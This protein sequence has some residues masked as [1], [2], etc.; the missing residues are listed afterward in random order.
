MSEPAKKGG[1]WTKAMLI[2]LLGVGGGAAGTYATAVVDRVVK[3]TKPVAN[4]ATSADGLTLT[5]Q[6]HASGESG[7]WDFGDGSALEPFKADGQAVTHAYAKPGTYT[8]KLTVRNYFSDENERSV[9]VE[10]GAAKDAPVPAVSGFAVLPVSGSSVAPATFRLTAEVKNA[11]NSVCDFGGRLEVADGGKIDRMV[12]FDTPGTYGVQLIAHN[13]KQA[14]KQT[15]TVTVTAP[16]EGTTMALLKVTDGGTRV[17]RISLTETVAIPVP[18][19]KKA[20]FSKAV[21]ARPGFVIADVTFPGAVAG[22]KNIKLAIAAN[23]QSATL[24]GDWADPKTA[25]KAAGGSDVIVPLKMVEER[26]RPL[27]TA[28]TLVTGAF[29][30]GRADLPLPSPPEGVT[31]ATRTFEIEIRATTGGKSATV[32]Q[33]KGAVA[34]PWSGANARGTK[35]TAKLDGDKVVVTAGR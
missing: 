16:A 32:A 12:T 10:V 18:N 14:V 4:F 15:A 31:G 25:N 33:G 3:P 34:L 24:S 9:P 28:T 35:Y 27:P 5:C 2:G 30:G 21:A 22:A 11:D 20:G 29:V 7:W 8:V 19:D 17:E 26:S 23:K 13:G 1:G 6:N